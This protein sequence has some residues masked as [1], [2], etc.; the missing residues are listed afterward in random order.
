MEI[1]QLE[2]F[3]T[4]AQ[5]GSFTRAAEQL[6]ISQPSLSARIRQLEY[7]LN[8]QLI[9]RK[10][11]PVSLTPAGKA[12]FTY[13]ERALAILA[14]AQES[15]RSANQVMTEEVVVGCP[16]SVATYLMPKVV[17]QFSQMFPDGELSIDTGNS[18]YVVSRLGDSLIN[19]AI[20]AA[21]PKFL[22]TNQTL[23]RLH[24]QMTVAV[25]NNHPLIKKKVVYLADLWKYR[26][27]L[28][29]WGPAFQVYIESMRQLVH[30][31]GPL[32]RLPLAG[33]LPM[34][35]QSDTITF[36][37]RRLVASSGL[38]ELH[39]FDLSF[40]WDIALLTRQG[41]TV[42]PLEN[43]FIKIIEDVWQHSTPIL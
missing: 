23:L 16:F 33:A 7:S 27:L 13:A 37:P 28:I 40:A 41:H 2:A 34:A 21:F 32:L 1:G 29:H 25:P 17:D 9:D 12:F 4:V 31:P 20:A 26:V 15:V 39:V 5:E 19:L 42:T 10:S 30:H 43:A 6:N 38:K 11:R 8:G 14:A 22:T 3:V 36:M 18:E 24:D 35:H